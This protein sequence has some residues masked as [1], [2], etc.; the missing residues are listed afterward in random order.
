LSQFW[1]KTPKTFIAK[2]NV[3]DFKFI[4]IKGKVMDEVNA[5]LQIKFK[6]VYS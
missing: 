5:R 1:F 3:L 4:K 2:I 6:L